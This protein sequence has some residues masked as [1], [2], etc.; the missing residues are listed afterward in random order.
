MFGI[1][2]NLC[3]LYNADCLTFP[4]CREKPCRYF[5]EGTGT[6]PFG[7]S[8]F[9]KHGMSQNNFCKDDGGVLVTC[10]LSSVVSKILTTF[11]IVVFSIYINRNSL[12]I[13]FLRKGEGACSIL[14]REVTLQRK[15][16][17]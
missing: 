11:F 8:C 2:F 12:Q 5:A 6:C 1:R 15:F 10:T 3:I 4:F 9:Y 13:A 14:N 7:S 17:Q 16:M